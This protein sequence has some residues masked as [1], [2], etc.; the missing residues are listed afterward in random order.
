[1]VPCGAPVQV[2]TSQPEATEPAVVAVTGDLD[3]GTA[4]D[5][6]ASLKDALAK[7][8]RSLVVDLLGVTFIDSMALGV[9]VRVYKRVRGGGGAMAIVCTQR[10]LLS[11]FE[12]TALDRLFPLVATVDAARATLAGRGEPAPE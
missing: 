8:A 12:I 6:E 1:V 3:I 4:A 2:S 10:R 11:V 9:L 5:F 7:G